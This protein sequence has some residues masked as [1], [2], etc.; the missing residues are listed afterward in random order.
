MQSLLV[1]EERV[2]KSALSQG[3]AI[4]EGD[5]LLVKVVRALHDEDS[6]L[7]RNDKLKAFM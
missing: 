7:L 6:Y 3:S 2:R 4:L 5:V 1:K